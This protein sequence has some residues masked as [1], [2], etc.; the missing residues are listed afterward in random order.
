MADPLSP[1][2]RSALMAKVRS[3]GNRSTELKVVSAFGR[4]RG[5]RLGATATQLHWAS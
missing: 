2:Q 3:T 5:E 4:E 1:E